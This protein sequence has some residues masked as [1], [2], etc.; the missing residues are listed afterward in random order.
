MN[1]HSFRITV[2][3]LMLLAMVF[4]PSRAPTAVAHNNQLLYSLPLTRPD[5]SLNQSYA[6]EH[7]RAPQT[8]IDAYIRPQFVATMEALQP[9]IVEAAR[10]HN[11]QRLSG[12]SDQEFA[13]VLA[14]VLYNENFGSFEDAVSP[15]RPL[16]PWYQ[17]L[18]MQANEAVGGTN[19]SVWPANL[20]PS[21]ADEILRGS[22]PLPGGDV[23]IIPLDV[24]GSAI[25]LHNH[26]SRGQRYAALTAEL[27]QPQLA[28]E[29]LAANL[30]RGVYRARYENVPVTWRA[31][32]AWHNQ[33]IVAPNAIRANPVAS[34][35]LR[36]SSAYVDAAHDLV[37]LAYSCY[38][39]TC[40]AESAAALGEYSSK[41]DQRHFAEEVEG[42]RIT[43]P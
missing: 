10:R 12:M 18:Q 24:E 17:G 38:P 40:S 33:G 2:G 27:T 6:T 30:E 37:A 4:Y 5:A 43:M 3:A 11:N 41:L 22:V 7:R 15:L 26:Q 13:E 8:S 14:L 31:L 9:T 34:D 23:L 35:Y 25:D 1:W 21:V 16:T 36:R 28:V 19:F 39:H 42:Q 20:R 29:Y 32:A